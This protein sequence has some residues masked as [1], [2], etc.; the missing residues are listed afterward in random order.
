MTKPKEDPE[1]QAAKI[2]RRREQLRLSQQ[3]RRDRLKAEGKSP[4]EIWNSGPSGG[5][6]TQNERAQ[7]Y[8]DRKKN[9]VDARDDSVSMSDTDRG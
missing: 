3:R 8:R 2:A 9:V 1:A 4:S 7:R 5:N 6:S